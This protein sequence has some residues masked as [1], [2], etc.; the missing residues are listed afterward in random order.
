VGGPGG[1]PLAIATQFG[2][3]GRHNQALALEH[4]SDAVEISK[5][6]L[7]EQHELW[8]QWSRQT[9]PTGSVS[10]L[11]NLL[12]LLLEPA[13]ANFANA[14][15]R[16]RALLRVGEGL[17]ACERFRIA[18]GR[19]PDDVNELVPNYVA[20]PLVDPYDGKP[21]RMAR[22]S[23]GLTLY[24][25][26]QD[27]KDDGAKFHPNGAALPGYDVGLRLWNVDK[28]HAPAETMQ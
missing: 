13:G 28:R 14:Y 2:A 12:A 22:T 6:P 8:A 15:V 26:G 16:S 23:D 3:Y 5:R 27:L 19:W 7:A 1:G 20:A 4:M 17:A 10:R 24:S 21:L 9:A 11:M 25:V 18:N